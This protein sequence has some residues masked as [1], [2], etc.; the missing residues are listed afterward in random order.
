MLARVVVLASALAGSAL[1]L[2]VAGLQAGHELYQYKFPCN[3]RDQCHVTSVA[4]PSHPDAYD[5]DIV[6]GDR[7]EIRAV[8]EGTFQEY[9]NPMA[10]CDENGGFGWHAVVQDIHGRTLIYAHLSGSAGLQPGARVLQGDLIGIE[11]DSGHTHHFPPPDYQHTSCADHLHLAGVGTIPGMDGSS[12]IGLGAHTSTNSPIGNITLPGAAIRQKYFNL[13]IPFTSWA[14]VGWTA[15]SGQTGCPPSDEYCQLNVHYVPDVA[16]GHWGSKQKFRQHADPAGFEFSS[17]MVGRWAVN[18]AYWV[19]K[20]LF[21]LWAS[22][23]QRV[24]AAI[25][26]ET[27]AASGAMCGPQQCCRSASP[28][29]CVRYQRFHLGYLW[30]KQGAGVQTPVFCPDVH[31]PYPNKDYYVNTLDDLLETAD[32]YGNSDAGLQPFQPWLD[33]GYDINGDGFINLFDDILV[34]AQN[35]GDQCWV[36]G[37][38]NP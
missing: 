14:T 24:G 22:D 5:F 3:P 20:G 21:S 26:D 30:E 35:F 12:S 8:S 31:P 38:D 19:K 11:G 36:G 13:G 25:R 10:V 16:V 17:I 37:I 15:T 9:R 28:W 7:G 4:G 34:V 27:S 23:N 29:F 18:D 2:F 6:L 32:R 33:A 1:L